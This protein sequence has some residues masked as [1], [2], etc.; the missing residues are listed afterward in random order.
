MLWEHDLLLH[1]ID[2]GYWVIDRWALEQPAP[3]ASLTKV[4]LPWIV[5]E[6]EREP[7]LQQIMSSLSNRPNTAKVLFQMTT[8]T[9]GN[10]PT[11]KSW[12]IDQDTSI[13]ERA[14]LKAGHKDGLYN[15][16][17]HL[18][19]FLRIFNSNLNSLR[20]QAHELIAENM[21]WAILSLKSMSN[22]QRIKGG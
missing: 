4:A 22:H 9:C 13:K 17:I 5:L 20:A 3:P 21:T 7:T 11:Q 18:T 15:L 2:G 19:F 10:F 1:L 12:P 16:I 14:W 6:L 8:K